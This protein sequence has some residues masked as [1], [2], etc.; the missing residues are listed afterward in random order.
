MVPTLRG[1]K[2]GCPP[3]LEKLTSGVWSNPDSRGIVDKR[4]SPAT[5]LCV[6]TRVT[7]LTVVNS[8][9]FGPQEREWATEIKVKDFTRYA[10]SYSSKNKVKSVS[11]LHLNIIKNSAVRLKKCFHKTRSCTLNFTDMHAQSFLLFLNHF[12]V[13]F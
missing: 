8:P 2:P 11:Q 10:H 13:Q 4:H 7:V 6:R 5:Y 12:H 9:D 3:L 1:C